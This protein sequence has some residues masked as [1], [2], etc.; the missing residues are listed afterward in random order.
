MPKASTRASTAP[1]R[2][3]PQ[4]GRRVLTRKRRCPRTLF[5]VNGTCYRIGFQKHPTEGTSGWAA[6]TE[7]GILIMPVVWAKTKA[8]VKTLLR[9]L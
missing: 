6:F 4:Q 1:G 8:G 3:V 5:R 2:T 7:G 9:Q